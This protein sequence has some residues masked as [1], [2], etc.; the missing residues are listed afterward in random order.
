ML[1]ISQGMYTYLSLNSLLKN[2]D[3]C[4]ADSLGKLLSVQTLRHD[5]RSPAVM[6]NS[7]VAVCA[8]EPSTGRGGQGIGMETEALLGLAG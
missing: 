7:G 2:I 3:N 1:K 6:Q 5:F 4:G 8:H